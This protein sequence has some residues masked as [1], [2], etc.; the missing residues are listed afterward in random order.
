MI[1]SFLNTI[2]CLKSL[3]IFSFAFQMID[4]KRYIFLLIF[5]TSVL[6]SFSQKTER[7]QMRDAEKMAISW[8]NKLNNKK[9]TDCWNTL[10][11]STKSQTN[12]EAWNAYFS[13]ELMPELGK[14]ISRKYYLAEMEKEMEGLPR[15]IYVTIRYQSQYVNT[16]SI[17]EILLLSPSKLGKW[18]V[19]SYFVDYHLKEDN[20]E[21]PKSK[22]KN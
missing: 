11:E 1:S 3:Y 18:E 10:S 20:R 15:G 4:M 21:N 7:Q 9:Y 2:K 5:S 12:F 13:T 14:F 16:D 17:E 19:L 22:L 8:L 6:F